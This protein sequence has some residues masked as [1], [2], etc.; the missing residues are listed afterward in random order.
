MTTLR[1]G[2][3]RNTGRMPPERASE[4]RHARRV[5]R[6]GNERPAPRP[7]TLGRKV[8]PHAAWAGG[9]EKPAS[10]TSVTDAL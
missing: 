4:G 7:A 1:S 9:K 8:P 5:D 3:A 6:S 10:Q 2:E